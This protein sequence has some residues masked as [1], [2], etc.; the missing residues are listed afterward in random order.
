MILRRVACRGCPREALASRAPPPPPNTHTLSGRGADPVSASGRAARRLRAGFLTL[1]LI[2]LGAA[3]L[4]PQIARAQDQ[5]PALTAAPGPGQVTLSWT[6]SSLGFTTQWR[7]RQKEGAGEYGGWQN[8]PGGEGI[9]RHTIGGLTAG[10]AYTFQVTGAYLTGV[11][12]TIT[13]YANPSNEASAT[14]TPV[15]SVTLTVARIGNGVTLSWTGANLPAVVN[16]WDVRYTAGSQATGNYSR[17]PGST[18]ATNTHTITGL[19]PGSY[20]FQVRTARS[21]G[22]A[23]TES[24]QVTVF[25]STVA[26]TVAGN[27]EWFGFE[28]VYDGPTDGAVSWQ[29]EWIRLSD[30]N[31]EGRWLDLPG[32]VALREY[33]YSATNGETGVFRVR[34]VGP[35]GRT[36]IASSVFNNQGWIEATPRAATPTL[37]SDPDKTVTVGSAD[38]TTDVCFNLLSV[39]QVRGNDNLVW[40]QQRTGGNSYINRLANLQ[41][42]NRVE[43]T[44]AP[45]G[46]ATGLGVG[47]F[48]CATL[49]VGTHTVTWSWKGRDGTAVAATTSTTITVAVRDSGPKTITLSASPSATITEGDSGSTDVT[50]TFT[51][52]EPAPA[53]FS[54]TSGYDVDPGTAAGS[55]KGR[56]PCDPP[57]LPVDTDMCFPNGVIVSIAEGQTQGTMTVRILGDTRDEPDETVNL[58]GYEDGWTSGKLTLT[59]TDDDE[60]AQPAAPTGLSAT[61]GNAQVTLSW[62][63]PDDDSISGYQVQQRKGSAAW[64]SWTDISGSDA[65]TTNHTVTG[66]DNDSQ[67]RFRIRAKSDAGNSVASAVV[68]GTPAEPPA[69]AA[70]AKPAGFGATKGDTQV[71]LSWTNPNDASITRWEYRQKAGNGSYGSW[72]RIAGSGATTVQ[73]R[74]TGLTNS[75]IY[76]FR[77]RAVNGNGNGAASDEVTATPAAPVAPVLTAATS[78][79]SGRIDV[80]WTHTSTSLGDQVANAVTFY[81]WRIGHRLK[82]SSNWAE[83]GSPSGASSPSRR[84]SRANPGNTYPDGAS[85]EVRIRATATNSGGNRVYGPWSNI[86]TVTF[87]N[88][89]LDALTF[90]GAPVTVVAGSS[91]SYTVAL[92]KEY[93]GTLSITSSATAKATVDPATLTF[94][95]SNYSTGQTVTVTGVEAGTATINHA[96]RLTGAAADA[97]PDAGTVGVTV[98]AAPGVTVSTAALT[99]AE[100]GSNTYTMR[101]NTAPSSDVTIMVDGA[102]GDVTVANATLTFTTVNW[103]MAQTVTVNAGTDTDTATDDA[104]TLTHSASG[105]GYD[106]VSIASVVV[107]VT[108]SGVVPAK[109]TGLAA[110]AGDGSVTLSWTDAGNPTITKWQYRRKAGSGAWDDWTDIGGSGAGTTSYKVSGLTNGTAYQFEVRAVNGAG[111]G[112]GPDAPVSATPT[113]AAPP[114]APPAAGGSVRVTPTA[115]TVEEGGSGSYTVVLGAE[116]TGPVTVTV[117][118]ASG[119]VTVVP[120]R[121]TFTASNWSEPQGVTV[122]AARDADTADD[123]ATLTHGA[124]GGGYDSVSIASVVVRVRDT[125]P[126]LSLETDPAAVSEGE[127]I[128]LVVTSDRVLTGSLVVSLT[129]AARDGGGF[130]GEDLPGGLGPRSLDAVFGA[131]ASRRGLVMIPTRV[132]GEAEGRESYRITLNAAPGYAVGVDAVAEGVLEEGSSSSANRVNRAI[133]PHVAALALSQTLEAVTG[134]IEAVSDGGAGGTVR[135]G[136]APGMVVDDEWVG[137]GGRGQGGP[138]LRELLDGASFALPLGA[139]G[140]GGVAAP[141]LWGVGEWRSLSGS[142]RDLSWE[143]G[144]WSGYLGADVRVRPD[145]LAGAAVSYAKGKVDAVSRGGDGTKSRHESRVVSVNPYLAWLRADGTTLWASAGYGRGEVRITEAG[146][147][148]R[149]A[150]LSQWS[151]A[152][153]GRGV[154]LEDPELIAGGTTRVA[155]KGEGSLVQ[156]DT[157]AGDGLTEL[158]VKASRLRLMLEGSWEHRVGGDA[159]LT[160]ALEVGVRHDDGDVGQGGG[161]EVGAGVTWRDPGAR[162]TAELRAR[163]L[164]VHERDREE[165]G[166]SA[167]VRLDP[168]ADGRGSYLSFG[169]THGRT[170]SG[171]GRLFDYGS[172]MD[173]GAGAGESRLE[174]EMGHGIGIAGPAPLALLTPYAGLSLAESGERTLRLGARYRLGSGVA[175]GIEG[176][177]RPWTNGEQ[178]LMLRGA[179]RW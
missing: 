65:D 113:A 20:T 76:T 156:L 139:S 173:S 70:P 73:H 42:N 60:A 134:R 151:G 104:V 162:L 55:G 164:A 44:Q 90:T 10:V 26:L 46:I 178:G 153:G 63:D 105:G 96:F 172:A 132:D 71:V 127:D 37:T 52:S 179:L 116:P 133:L 50:I 75:T 143:G 16:Q 77:I 72:T 128:R 6:M 4:A 80:T 27:D 41:G 12:R 58:I 91:V 84:N 94:S 147:A 45:A 129:L 18:G 138:G 152:A 144:L 142:E 170:A 169:P 101:L 38:A 95:A 114:S 85:V 35:G 137:P 53:N 24:N 15:P 29:L 174:A 33:G 125:T 158:T 74:I 108:E 82:G 168:G 159:T 122:S 160:P 78:T 100:G 36:E 140:A 56:D 120:R 54:L 5:T 86:R 154:L 121:L 47:L 107:S 32:G 149:T 30:R 81:A 48:P 165:W 98:A 9:R 1:F 67:Y 57:L 62:T 117:G 167:L 124:R 22:A 79:T 157:E 130:D 171:L 109:P 115:L 161:V 166:V 118:G 123:R 11:R 17:I 97:I 7:Y 102:S 92:T 40:L 126:V 64:G 103:N 150:D 14:P 66:L 34:L 155:V 136:A 31:G 69:G 49:G 110:A 177:S 135:F 19:S 21:D 145:L 111:N 43:I 23:G 112:A 2:V 28:W 51:L 59:I 93:A 61:A 99:V 8:I 39:K 163:M 146:A 175:L 141:A 13:N 25:V 83:G 119:E 106:S 3:A 131:T 148:A 89:A 68:S 176:T 87:K 88:D